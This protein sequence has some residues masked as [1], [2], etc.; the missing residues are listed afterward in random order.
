MFVFR[1]LQRPGERGRGN[2][3]T[4][5]EKCRERL[6]FQYGREVIAHRYI[7]FVKVIIR[8]GNLWGLRIAVG[9]YVVWES[10]A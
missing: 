6:K 3:A 4:P 8:D 10:P 7:A 1:Y 9:V 5:C 2:Q